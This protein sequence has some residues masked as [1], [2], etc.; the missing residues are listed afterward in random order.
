MYT[1]FPGTFNAFSKM[2]LY[3][4]PMVIHQFSDFLFY[5]QGRSDETFGAI[6]FKIFYS[7]ENNA[8]HV[9]GMFVVHAFC[10][11]TFCF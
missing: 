11:T 6:A 7:Q 9:D 2:H 10:Q 4:V 8:L 1:P 3:I 5:F